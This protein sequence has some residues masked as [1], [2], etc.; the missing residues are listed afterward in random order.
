MMYI[1]NIENVQ[2]KKKKKKMMVKDFKE[3]IF[4][5]HYKPISFTKKDSFFLQ[6]I[7]DATKAREHY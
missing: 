5:N 3:F 7:L 6:K 1:W 4:K 2:K